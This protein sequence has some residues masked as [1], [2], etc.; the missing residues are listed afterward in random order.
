MRY[1]FLEYTKNDSLFVI[2]LLLLSV[3]TFPK[4][5]CE[6]SRCLFRT[7]SIQNKRNN[8][9]GFKFSRTAIILLCA[10]FDYIDQIT[11]INTV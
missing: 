11:E 2:Y 3:V 4:N 1:F 8:V 7:N 5:F 6:L 10:R 9:V